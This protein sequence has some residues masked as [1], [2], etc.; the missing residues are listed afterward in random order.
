M[1]L[2]SKETAR[3][4]VG[5]HLAFRVKG[6]EDALSGINVDTEIRF[7]ERESQVALSC[8]GSLC[9]MMLSE[10]LAFYR[11]KPYYMAVR[12]GLIMGRYRPMVIDY[13]QKLSPQERQERLVAT[14]LGAG[15][16]RDFVLEAIRW[17]V[18]CYPS[19]RKNF[20]EYLNHSE[21]LQIAV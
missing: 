1:E 21:Y 20:K 13:V 19:R 4:L 8:G 11:T 15:E 3:Y 9:V 7:L 5:T 18:H 6:S 2:V 14:L 17:F 16:N 12:G 10:L